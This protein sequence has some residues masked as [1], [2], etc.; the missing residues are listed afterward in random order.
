MGVF[1]GFLTLIRTHLLEHAPLDAIALLRVRVPYD[2]RNGAWLS[3]LI[4]VRATYADL[5]ITTTT[6]P[7]PNPIRS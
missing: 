6:F 4:L 3:I 1:A 7:Q 5:L 2:S